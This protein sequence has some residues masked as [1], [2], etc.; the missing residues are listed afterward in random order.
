MF[1]DILGDSG[2]LV[3]QQ[4]LRK[5]LMQ[6]EWEGGKRVW[7]QRKGLADFEQWLVEKGEP[8]SITVEWA[9]L[10]VNTGMIL[11]NKP[12]LWHSCQP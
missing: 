3:S 6:I 1:V 10:Q 9:D 7:A 12:P 11:L 5:R 4:Q 8:E 2:Y